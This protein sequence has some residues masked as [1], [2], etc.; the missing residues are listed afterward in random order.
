MS[1]TAQAQQTLGE[2]GATALDE[3]NRVQAMMTDL[4]DREN[5]LMQHHANPREIMEYCQQ[6]LLKL[7]DAFRV[8]MMYAPPEQ[9]PEIQH[10]YVEYRQKLLN[11]LVQAQLALSTPSRTPPPGQ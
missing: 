9:K 8:V 6:T 10:S 7:D 11:L 2:V 1:A 4:R 5:D 3:L